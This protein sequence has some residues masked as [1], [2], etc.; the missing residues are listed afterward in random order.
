MVSELSKLLMETAQMVL[1]ISRI[2][3]N[4]YGLLFPNG[5]SHII[6]HIIMLIPN[7]FFPLEKKNKKI[8]DSQF[9]YVF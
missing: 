6:S 4:L 9:K 1:T 3:L 8:L 2:P 5:F 7:G